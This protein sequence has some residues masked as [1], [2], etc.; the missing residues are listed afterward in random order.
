MNANAC[1]KKRIALVSMTNIYLV[2]YIENY[3][4]A[5][6]SKANIDVIYWDRHRVKEKMPEVN[7]ITI[8]INMPESSHKFRKL[9]GY[10]RFA[11][12]AIRY[13]ILGRYDRVVLLTTSPAILFFPVLKIL[14][15]KRYIVE[16]RDYTAE[17][18]CIVR[19]IEE[20]LFSDAQMLIVSS[21]GFLKFLPRKYEYVVAHNMPNQYFLTTS[22]IEASPRMK[23]PI[24]IGMIGLIRFHDTIKKF[25]RKMANDER[26]ELLFIGKGSEELE[27]FLLHESIKNVTIEGAFDPSMT[28]DK[29]ANV[30]IVNN[31]YG[32]GLPQLDYALSNKL[33]I[34]AISKKPILVCKGTYMQEV[35][36]G[37]NIAIDLNDLNLSD[38]IYDCYN[39]VKSDEI[40]KAAASFITKCIEDQNK[41]MAS[42]ASMI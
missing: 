6:S 9:A 29:Y 30:D 12:I 11:I 41:Y 18:S 37:F 42:I 20:L 3:I 31:L 27:T 39:S 16:I 33:Y 26:F 22:A 34:A 8:S 2:P 25:I 5:L 40:T 14:F 23:T 38:E 24:R 17:Y 1:D 32:N 36:K 19:L 21:R 35:S 4:R 10:I 28:F 15:R 7:L 13:L